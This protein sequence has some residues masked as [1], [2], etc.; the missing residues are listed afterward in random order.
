MDDQRELLIL[1]AH[2]RG[3]GWKSIHR[4][5]Q[6]DNSLNFLHTTSK[7]NLRQILRIHHSNFERFYVDLH[8]LSVKKLIHSYNKHN[9]KILTIFDKEYPPLLKEIYDPPWVLFAKG[10]VSLLSH[11]RML[12]IVGTRA[13]SAYGIHAVKQI[14]PSLIESGCVIISGLA[15]GID[16]LAHKTAIQNQGYTIAVIA[17]GFNHIYPAS[18]VS[19]AKH[20][21]SNHLLLSEYPP[22]VQPRKW[23][24]PMRNR[25]ISGLSKGTFVIEARQ[26]SGSLITADQALSQGR[27]VFSLP[28]HVFAPT[29]EG[30]NYLI[31]Q[32]AKLIMNAND[33]ITEIE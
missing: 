18:N 13:P 15:E 26:K 17:G 28:G 23:Q 24:F 2:C 8:N 6:V 22:D 27:D 25:I 20:I 31:Q 29:S 30:T 5:I 10:K 1:L 33:V 9:I 7:D 12:S 3:I 19:L 11:T 32:G 16:T 4:L 14:L 21:A